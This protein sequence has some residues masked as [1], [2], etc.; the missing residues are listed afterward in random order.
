MIGEGAGRFAPF[1]RQGRQ[2]GD[3]HQCDYCECEASQ[4]LAC[5]T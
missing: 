3:G 2:N 1:L 4:A 5:L